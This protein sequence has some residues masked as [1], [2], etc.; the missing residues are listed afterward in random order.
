MC[1]CVPR[2]A[3][4]AQGQSVLLPLPQHY[5]PIKAAAII[6]L[7]PLRGTG[8]HRPDERRQCLFHS[9]LERR[10]LQLQ[11]PSVGR[12]NIPECSR[13]AT[14]TP[15]C[16]QTHTCM[17]VNKVCLVAAVSN[18][19][20]WHHLH[21]FLAQKLNCTMDTWLILTQS[22]FFQLIDWFMCLFKCQSPQLVASPGL[23]V[24]SNQYVY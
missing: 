22:L 24:R 10:R 19:N 23:L 14:H 4:F 21:L 6:Y 11:S 3:L 18:Q 2:P 8:T 20:N 7:P 13:T 17:H 15:L 16:T 1:P 12:A 5:P 9:R